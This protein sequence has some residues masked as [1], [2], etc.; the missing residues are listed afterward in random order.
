MSVADS[1]ERTLVI[2][3]YPSFSQF[4]SRFHYVQAGLEVMIPV[5]T[6]LSRWRAWLQACATMIMCSLNETN[7]SLKIVPGKQGES[8]QNF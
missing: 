1:V 7:I 8:F 2:S 5:S 4:S 6:L 3:S